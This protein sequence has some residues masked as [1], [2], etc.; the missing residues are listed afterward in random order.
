MA[1]AP[2]RISLADE[3]FFSGL[4]VARKAVAV[5]KMLLMLFVAPYHRSSNL[6]KR[7]PLRQRTFISVVS[8]VFFAE[9]VT[10]SS[11]PPCCCFAE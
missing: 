4:F 1:G 10:S 8:C 3:Y 6:E 9:I 2:L 7:L 5:A 11:S